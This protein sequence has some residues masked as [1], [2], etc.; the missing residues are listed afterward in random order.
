MEPMALTVQEF[1]RTHSISRG[2]F[3]NL[4]AEGLAPK[5]MRV[6][7][8]VLVSVEAAAEWR[9]EMEK[10]AAEGEAAAIPGPMAA[11]E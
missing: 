3:Y 7:G 1:C 4:A 11:A 10:R 9:K 8:R 5:V 2:T 6:R